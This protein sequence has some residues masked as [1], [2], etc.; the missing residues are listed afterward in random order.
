LSSCDPKSF[1]SA[2]PG[3]PPPSDLAELIEREFAVIGRRMRNVA[4]GV[5][6]DALP[7]RRHGSGGLCRM[8]V[9]GSGGSGREN[10]L[11]RGWRWGDWAVGPE[12][13]DEGVAGPAGLSGARPRASQFV[14]ML[15]VSRD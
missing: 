9:G 13:G 12:S 5:C 1:E 4:V 8:A 6:M 2:R 14:L 7:F 10:L 11:L 3:A 15:P